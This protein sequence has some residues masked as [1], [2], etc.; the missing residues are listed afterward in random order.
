[1][2]GGRGTR[3]QSATP[4]FL[5]ELHGKPMVRWVL[6]AAR[7][8]D[9]RRLVVVFPPRTPE[10]FTDVEVTVQAQPLGTADAV[11][12]AREALRSFAGD[13][14][15][16]SADTPLVTTRTLGELVEEHRCR[17]AAVTVL[18]FEWPEPLPYGRLVRG[19]DGDL[20]AIVEEADATP[21]Q[22]RIGELNSSIYVFTSEW[23]W[24]G[25]ARVDTANA[26]GELQ[27]TSSIRH[28]VAGGGKAAVYEAPDPIEALGVNTPAELAFAAEALRRRR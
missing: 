20:V 3:M 28:I 11:A 10:V 14:L 9:P 13:V 21:E 5:T 16:L 17:R 27:L 23:L 4:K 12:S 1:M 25:I 19:A 8:I 18:S 26:K 2:A 15:V 7:G 6:E 22:R 24:K